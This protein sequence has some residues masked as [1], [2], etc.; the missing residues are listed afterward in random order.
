MALG[1]CSKL[2]TLNFRGFFSRYNRGPH[3]VAIIIMIGT[4]YACNKK[5]SLGQNMLTILVPKGTKYA[6]NH[7]N[8]GDQIC[9]Q[10]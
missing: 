4:I 5:E 8:N 10:S 1:M 9:L 3:K 7:D 2:R 6:C